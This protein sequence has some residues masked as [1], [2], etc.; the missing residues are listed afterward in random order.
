MPFAGR[1]S[2][3]RLTLLTLGAVAAGIVIAM[4]AGAAPLPD[5]ESAAL[6]KSV[7]GL[8]PQISVIARGVWSYAEVGWKVANSSARLQ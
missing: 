5:S 2:L 1:E 4:P 3:M 6:Q 7:D 8:A